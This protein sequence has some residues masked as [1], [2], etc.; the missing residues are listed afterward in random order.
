MDDGK[1]C[2]IVVLIVLVFI[3]VGCLVAFKAGN[4]ATRVITGVPGGA[5][6]RCVECESA[7]VLAGDVEYAASMEYC[8]VCGRKFIKTILEDR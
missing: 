6:I 4:K 5:Q 8:P 1:G 7:V 3:L 2:I